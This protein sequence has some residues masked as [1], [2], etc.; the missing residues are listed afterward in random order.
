MSRRVTIQFYK[1]VSPIKQ[2]YI[3]ILRRI[4]YFLGSIQ[5]DK[6][7][8]FSQDALAELPH[9]SQGN[10]TPDPHSMKTVM[11][12]WLS[13]ATWQCPLYSTSSPLC[14]PWRMFCL[15]SLHWD[16]QS[17]DTYKLLQKMAA[18]TKRSYMCT[19]SLLYYTTLCSSCIVLTI[20]G[21]LYYFIAMLVH[22]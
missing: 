5:H 14:R 8:H 1:Y 3:H 22:I 10:V 11:C 20:T 15:Q 19:S 13:I 2:G 6:L 12:Q 4:L 17:L 16:H 21:L 9:S 7:A 18:P